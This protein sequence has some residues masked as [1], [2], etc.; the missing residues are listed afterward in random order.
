M[1]RCLWLRIVLI[2]SSASLRP[3]SRSCCFPFESVITIFTDCEGYGPEDVNVQRLVRRIHLKV[4][5]LDPQV[6]RDKKKSGRWERPLKGSNW[7]EWV[8]RASGESALAS[9]PFRV[10]VPRSAGSSRAAFIERAF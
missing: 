1:P 6:A 2:H 10:R 4:P 5:P 9:S 3:I 7:E 8:P